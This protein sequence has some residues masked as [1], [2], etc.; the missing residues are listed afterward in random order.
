MQGSSDL[1]FR[2]VDLLKVTTV[3]NQ[4][5]EDERLSWEAAHFYM[6]AA[7]YVE[8][9]VEVTKQLMVESYKGG[10]G[11]RM[12]LRCTRELEEL[13]YLV[14]HRLRGECGRFG[15]VAWE[16][17]LPSIEHESM[18]K[19][20]Y[21]KEIG[22]M[23]N[24]RSNPESRFVLM[25]DGNSPETAKPQVRP[26]VTCCAHGDENSY[27]TKQKEV[28][29]SIP[30]H[31][32][33]KDGTDNSSNRLVS[34][35]QA[36]EHVSESEGYVLSNVDEETVAQA[37]GQVLP[38]CSN[39]SHLSDQLQQCR[40]EVDAMYE[41]PKDDSPKDDADFEKWRNIVSNALSNIVSEGGRQ[42]KLPVYWFKDYG[43][44]VRQ[45]A[46]ADWHC[47]TRMGRL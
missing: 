26:R 21:L 44:E 42:K 36:K 10:M 16:L 4:L 13:G 38:K 40:P 28:G 22:V 8:R 46:L 14:R 15:R 43:E 18:S 11:R 6:V 24:P 3:G 19:S 32:E 35:A 27:K 1:F 47:R 45:R 7:Y 12:Y 29:I 34:F 25:D 17:T 2:Q 30:I 9:G 33:R 39:L 20:R 5:F 31:I 23:Q 41:P 37:F